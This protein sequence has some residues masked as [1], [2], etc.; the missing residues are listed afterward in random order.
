QYDAAA[1][2]FKKA[3][4]SYTQEGQVPENMKA[5]FLTAEQSYMEALM[6][7]GRFADAINFATSRIKADPLEQTTMGP[8]IAH[9]VEQ[10]SAT[11]E[12]SAKDLLD[13]ASKMTPPLDEK[14]RQRLER[15]ADQFPKKTS[16]SETGIERQSASAKD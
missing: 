14:Y 7:G 16:S 3:L 9:K 4:D 1:D 11:D 2:H 12:K 13:R 6:D 5:R 15:V 10:L 8:L